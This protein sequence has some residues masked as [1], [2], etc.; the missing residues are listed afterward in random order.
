[1][2][3]TA[4]LITILAILLAPFL[5][6][7]AA[8]SNDPGKTEQIPTESTSAPPATPGE[9]T[10]IFGPFTKTL[11]LIGSMVPIVLI[12]LDLVIAAWVY[13][14]AS[15]RTRY[16]WLWGIASLFVI[17]WIL[18]LLWRPMYTLEERKMFETEEELRKIQHDYYLYVLSRE[19][20]ICSVCGTPLQSDYKL[21]PN[22][23]SEVKKTC[24]KCGKPIELDW[25]VCPYCGNR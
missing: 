4:L 23:Y 1:V 3:K 6:I 5:T 17:P 21:C 13:F 16:G 7:L 8:D 11:G 24:A 20:H 14:D 22:C 19:K 18:Y 10:D 12:G 2:K 15:R 9:S 25:K